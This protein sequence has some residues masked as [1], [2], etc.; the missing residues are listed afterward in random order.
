MNR[1]SEQKPDIVETRSDK[2]LLP[3]ITDKTLLAHRRELLEAGEQRFRDYKQRLAEHIDKENPV[4][5]RFITESLRNV[6]DKDKNKALELVEF[7]YRL[8]E[9]EA[10]ATQD[11]ETLSQQDITE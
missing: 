7:V 5:G 9:I 6:G 11:M 2:P 3:V 1:E 4:L 8:L 10:E